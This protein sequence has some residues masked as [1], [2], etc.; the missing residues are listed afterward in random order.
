MWANGKDVTR[1][2]REISQKMICE[3]IGERSVAHDEAAPLLKNK[4]AAVLFTWLSSGE[5]QNKI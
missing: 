1:R 3:V 4:M 2:Y 5:K